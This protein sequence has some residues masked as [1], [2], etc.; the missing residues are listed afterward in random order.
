MAQD[1]GTTSMRGVCHRSTAAKRETMFTRLFVPLDNSS[2]AEQALP[3]AQSLAKIAGAALELVYVHEP[4]AFGGYADEAVHAARRSTEESYVR[5]M[6]DEIR[7]GTG[8]TVHGHLATGVPADAICASAQE[9]GADLIVMTTHGRTGFN[10]AWIGSVADAVVREAS[11]PVLLLRPRDMQSGM[12]E[13]LPLKRVLVSVDGSTNSERILES[14]AALAKCL[15]G[16]IIVV[17]V[18]APIPLMIP[19]ATLAYTTLPAI[20]DAEA[21]EAVVRAAIGRL[22]GLSS[23]LHQL[24]VLNVETYVKVSRFPAQAIIDAARLHSADVIAMTTTGRGASRLLIGSVTDKVMR[25]THLPLLLH[26]PTAIEAVERMPKGARQT[27]TEAT[28]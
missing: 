20:S 10:R 15:D 16:R 11:I 14:A 13:A 12:K 28:V 19:D 22:G 3:T 18:V 7:N 5:A 9:M 2:L 26:R 4:E 23:R 1:Y 25:A 6:A 21:T 17:E 24:G 8:V 27:L